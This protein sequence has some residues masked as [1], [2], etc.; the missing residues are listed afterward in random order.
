[1]S[2]FGLYPHIFRN[3]VSFSC[4][5]RYQLYWFSLSK[6]QHQFPKVTGQLP[7]EAADEGTHAA[8]IVPASACLP[9]HIIVAS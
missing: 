7:V 3:C 1:M 4:V 2:F 6:Q 8:C 9:V 5:M